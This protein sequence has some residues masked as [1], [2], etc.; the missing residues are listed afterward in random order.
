VQYLRTILLKRKRAEMTQTVGV[1]DH[2]APPT[3]FGKKVSTFLATAR[4]AV[5]AFLATG[6]G[7]TFADSL[8]HFDFSHL[9]WGRVWAGLGV[10]LV[11]GLLTYVVRNEGA[12]L[13]LSPELIAAIQR[14]LNERLGVT[15]NVLG[16]QIASTSENLVGHVNSVGGNLSSH[17]TEQVETLRPRK[18]LRGPGGKF[19]PADGGPV[20]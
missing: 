5:V 15:E 20:I 3:P 13:G 16:H 1:A 12:K 17:V 9:T 7:V 4:K 2:A 6:I 19:Q 8:A 14:V 10:G 18:A 11:S